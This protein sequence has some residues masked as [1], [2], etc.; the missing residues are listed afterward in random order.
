MPNRVRPPIPAPLASWLTSRYRHGNGP[1]A[2]APPDPLTLAHG[3]DKEGFGVLH[4]LLGEAESPVGAAGRP[5]RQAFRMILSLL[6]PTEMPEVGFLLPTPLTRQRRDPELKPAQGRGA[7]PGG[8]NRE[9]FKDWPPVCC[10]SAASSPARG[11]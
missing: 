5:E 7:S 11:L 10:G 6:I 4:V 8:R 1:F 9:P 2:S 3:M